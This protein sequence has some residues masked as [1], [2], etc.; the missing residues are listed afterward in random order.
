MNVSLFIVHVMSLFMSQEIE[1]DGIRFPS[2]LDT[3]Y[4]VAQV[5]N[6]QPGKLRVK[7]LREGHSL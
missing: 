2:N 1:R 6:Q 3:P 7:D 5:L 4:A